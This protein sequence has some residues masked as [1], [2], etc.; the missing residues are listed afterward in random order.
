MG[1]NLK[2]EKREQCFVEIRF[3]IKTFWIKYENNDVVPKYCLKKM[4]QD[5]ERNREKNWKNISFFLNESLKYIKNDSKILITVSD[6][7]V[8]EEDKDQLIK[9]YIKDLENLQEKIREII[10]ISGFEN[11]I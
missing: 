10:K 11:K 9:S 8:S 6:Q 7:F 4:I 2:K 1:N 3:I 5:L